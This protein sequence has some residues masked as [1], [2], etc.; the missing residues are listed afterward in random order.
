MYQVL[1]EKYYDIGNIG[2][3]LVQT[4]SQMKSSGITLPEVHVMRK[5]LDLNILPEKQHANPI[6]GSVEKPCTDQGRAGLR[7]RR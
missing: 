6:K 5:N 4:C 1:H 2:N 7:R 3:Y